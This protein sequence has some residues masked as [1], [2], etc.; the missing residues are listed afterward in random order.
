MTNVPDGAQLSED[1]AWWWDGAEWRATEAIN[2]LAY[3]L[4]LEPR[5]VVVTTVMEHP[6]DRSQ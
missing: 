1:G 3:R 4:R 2:H 5:D 6:Q